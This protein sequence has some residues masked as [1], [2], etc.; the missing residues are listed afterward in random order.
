MLTFNAYQFLQ[1]KNITAAYL[2]HV[3]YKGHHLSYQITNCHYLPPFIE[4]KLPQSQTIKIFQ[5]KE[6]KVIDELP[7]RY[8]TQNHK[9]TFTEHM[10]KKNITVVF[11]VPLCKIENVVYFLNILTES[12]SI[13]KKEYLDLLNFEK[14]A[15]CLKI[16][17]FY[18]ALLRIQNLF[19]SYRKI[20]ELKG[21]ET[22]AHMERVAVFSHEIAL[23]TWKLANQLN[24]QDLL[25]K[26]S[27]FTFETLKLAA[28]IHDV[29][30][31][32]IP[33]N[34]LNKPSKLTKEEFEIIKTHSAK[35]IEILNTAFP[36]NGSVQSRLFSDELYAIIDIT[37]EIIYQ[38]HERMDGTGYPRGLKGQQI[39]LFSKIVSVA[40]VFDAITS[41][42]I[43]KEKQTSQMALAEMVKEQY[44][45]YDPLILEALL[46]T[47][48]RS[49]LESIQ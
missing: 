48:K 3:D 32:A 35:G 41:K 39:G 16:Q 30:K 15:I 6:I 18:S 43:Y 4:E 24:R 25:K 5:E 9:S 13:C 47:Q 33:E 49:L 10:I 29:G 34:I 14:E 46:R 8:I 37:K 27:P 20:L 23:N 40:D 38:H 26:F 31:L 11:R 7:L 2:S 17:A 28:T 21:D 45:K 19:L 44:E 42:R 12:D 22:F 1:D 36:Y